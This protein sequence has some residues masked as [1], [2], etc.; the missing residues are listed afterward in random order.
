MGVDTN[1]SETQSCA[2]CG[3]PLT[4][5]LPGSVCAACAL[6]DALTPPSDPAA[7]QGVF[8][9]DLP[10]AGEKYGRLGPF[11][12]IEP[13]AQGA[14]GIVY[15]ARQPALNRIVA[16]KVL[17][18]G[19]HASSEAKQRFRQEAEIVAG[20]SH[21]GIVPAHEF[22]EHH[23]ALFLA[24]DFVEG[25]DL[26]RVLQGSLPSLREAAGWMREAAEAVGF[27]HRRGVLHRDLKPSNILL[28]NDGRI[29]ITDFGLARLADGSQKL[30]R[31]GQ[32]FGSPGYLPPEQIEAD[33]GEA[34]PAS[35]V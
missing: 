17:V 15:K 16:V 25:R 24:T 34:S 11:E 9:D 8:L 10:L 6:R 4:E 26:G 23:G 29:R 1:P 22:G 20:L 19:V 14:M 3:Q 2:L 28:G 5:R 31:T 18:G 12:L 7:A 27:A 33:R 30:T 21:P 32:T 35:D 13:L